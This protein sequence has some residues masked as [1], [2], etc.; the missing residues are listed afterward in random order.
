MRRARQ[1]RRGTTLV[2]S[3]VVYPVMFFLL[4]A[5]LLGGLNVFH[6]QQMSWLSRE[7]TRWASVRGSMF[8]TETSQ[9]SPST[10]DIRAHVLALGASLDPSRLTVEVFF[11]DR[12]AGS[13]V[14]WDSSSKAPSGF[15]ETGESVSNRVRVTVRYVTLP[16]FFFTSPLQLTATSEVPMSF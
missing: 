2:E 4:L 6:Y 9:S 14:S 12:V 5:I 3:A 15:A 8:A 16:G 1:S 11:I 13:V 10:A 7:A